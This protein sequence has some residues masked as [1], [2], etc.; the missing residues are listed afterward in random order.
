[1]GYLEIIKAFFISLFLSSS[2]SYLG[3]QSNGIWAIILQLV[4]PDKRE[5]AKAML[6]E[7][8]AFNTNPYCTGVMI[9][10]ALND[11]N[12]IRQESFVTL[13]SIFGSIGD[14]YIWRTLRPT[15]LSV[16]VLLLMI[17][18]LW[19]KNIYAVGVFALTPLLFLIPYNIAVQGIRIKGIHQG[20]K[21]GVMAAVKLVEYLRRPITKFYN[22][23]AFVIGMIVIILPLVYLSSFARHI[24]GFAESIVSIFTILGVTAASYFLM[25]SERSSSYLLIAGLLIFLIIKVL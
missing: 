6:L 7:R 23:L 5:H 20:K 9:G 18:Y 22:L 15:V 21:I 2:W 8:S 25:R 24:N 17:G 12:Q 13:Q 14:E 1:M 10:I 3:R 11:E 4:K 16:S 19:I